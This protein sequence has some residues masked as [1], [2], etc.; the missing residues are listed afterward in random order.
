MYQN[1]LLDFATRALRAGNLAAAEIACRDLLDFEPQNA[2]ALHML[3]FIASR[4]GEK[5]QA[6][7]QPLEGTVGGEV[8]PSG[9][10]RLA[11]DAG[12]KRSSAE[13]LEV[14]RLSEL[15]VQGL[16]CNQQ[17][18]GGEDGEEERQ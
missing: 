17:R 16:E 8:R 15:A 6:V 14:G 3:G 18:G 13:A 5:D 9:S 4:V 1:E 7:A 2:A 11:R 12:E 10:E